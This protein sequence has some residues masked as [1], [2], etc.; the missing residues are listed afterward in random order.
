MTFDKRWAE[1]GQGQAT[2]TGANFEAKERERVGG[3]RGTSLSDLHVVGTHHLFN[4][5][6]ERMAG[7][8]QP[9]TTRLT[10]LVGC[11]LFHEISTPRFSNSIPP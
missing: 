4:G 7:A 5:A 6:W 8:T 10:L 9:C 3:C 1:D 2:P 11:M